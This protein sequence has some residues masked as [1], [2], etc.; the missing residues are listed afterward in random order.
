MSPGAS[1]AAEG[2]RGEV[3]GERGSFGAANGGDGVI[4]EFG[5]GRALC[6]KVA[7]KIFGF[8][9]L[10]VVADGAVEAVGVEENGIARKDGGAGLLAME[11]WR[12]ANGRRQGRQRL[13]GDGDA[14]D[15][16]GRM[17]RAGEVY[18]GIAGADGD[19]GGRHERFPFEHREVLGVDRS[20]NFAGLGIFGGGVAEK[21]LDQG[22]VERGG[23]AV[24]GD[25]GDPKEPASIGEPGPIEDIAA[26][27]DDGL[28]I[29]GDVPPF[30]RRRADGKHGLLGEAGGLE[31]QFVVVAPLFELGV[32][33]LQL[34]A[35]LVQADLGVDSRLEDSDIDGLRDE[36]VGPGGEALHFMLLAG[37]RCEEDDGKG[38]DRRIFM[39]PDH[40]A[41]LR[42]G[43]FGHFV[44]EHEEDGP[45]VF[46]ELKRFA[47]IGALNDFAAPPFKRAREQLPA[48]LV[49]FDE[50][51]A[52]RRGVAHGMAAGW[53]HRE[54]IERMGL[55]ALL[56]LPG[57]AFPLTQNLMAN[58]VFL[59]HMHQPY[60]VNPA[61]QTA[62]MPWVRLHG[63][64]GYLD[65]IS[66]IDDFPGVR[67][68]FNLTPVL[69]LQV[70]ELIEGKIRD[71]WLEWSR[72]PAAELEEQEKFAILENFF[73]LHWENLVKPYP[74]FW[75]LLNKRG[76][77]F[78]RDD[79]R[80]GLRY[81]SAQEY[82]DLQVW[83]NLAWCGYTAERLYPE[84]AELKRK[85]RN[86][87]ESEKQ[88]VLDLHIEIL[89]LVVRKY[90]EAEERGQV[91]LTTTPFFHPI[92]PLIYDSSFAERSLPGRTFPKRFQWPE[93][94]AAQITLA[95]EQHAAM[96][97][98]A[99]RGL[100][101]SEGSI[102]P[103]LIPLMERSGIEYFCSD[104]ENL[105]N[106]L[107]R[108]PA[109]KDKPVDHLELFQGWRVAYG[110][111]TVN[112]L[113]REKPL[114]DFI[115]FMAAKNAPKQ[116]ATHLLFHL[117]HISGLVPKDTGVIP[118]ILDG[119]NAWETFADGGEGFLR[120]LYGG[121]ESDKARL[122][123]CTIEDYFL[124]HPPRKQ[125]TTLHTASWIGSNF[126]I[127]IGEAEENRAWDLLGETRAFLAKQMA[128]GA[129]TDDQRCAALRE[130]Y[131]AEGSDWFWWYGPDF[132]TENDALFDD[133]FR[134]HLKN[135]YAI[136]GAVH[137]AELERPIA[138]RQVMT[139]YT[140]PERLISPT[141]TGKQP[142]FFEW[143]GAGR[144]TAGGRQ[145]AMHRS[146]RLIQQIFFGN[147]ER[148]LYVRCDFRKWEP[149]SLLIRFQQPADYSVETGALTRTGLQEFTLRQPDGTAVARKTLA[150]EDIL[151]LA[152]PLE[153]LGL[154]GEG[155]IAFQ[156]EVLEEGSERECHP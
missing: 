148:H 62:M 13:R 135:V 145:G 21:E 88:R 86:F 114:S 83:F 70:K 16:Q 111:S 43:E 131:A 41:D 55:L 95:V 31:I 59:W 32:L 76:L 118:L 25:V 73:K 141:I 51:D 154:E 2:D 26:D 140:L 64:K 96:F 99:P 44:I 92:L 52:G 72:K 81:F 23:D 12:D 18:A 119:E 152:I 9:T 150:V 63:V 29:S 97:G 66:I 34:H 74:R 147:D 54:E 58:V 123:S 153:D 17:A 38:G 102:A 5:G 115:G 117:R 36:I 45:G 105:F 33:L 91:E 78:Y 69:M 40:L 85:G 80:R 30:E 142:S 127:W 155:E 120:A 101:P 19:A 15:E 7:G 87:T 8:E 138:G 94:A 122:H 61:T 27:L 65:M 125:I 75:E 28:V 50:K 134:Q 47:S 106:S 79:V 112:A 60:Y 57:A 14:A 110:G 109:F 49:V 143:V 37:V 22:G 130:I 93:D 48:D 53:Q 133:L 4:H 42:A 71:L 139:L 77:T 121:I 100:W 128:A 113:F 1:L 129:L 67:V 90:R 98:R 137:P 156:V 24:A 82:L 56:L 149:V 20:E 46:D 116:A 126:D 89:R 107:K 146:D 104:E 84:L 39:L 11:G 3:V 35:H 124:H 108:D 151:E 10:S 144:F 68:N 6:G 132:S 103:E 136:C